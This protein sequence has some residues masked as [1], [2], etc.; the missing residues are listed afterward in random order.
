MLD[1]AYTPLWLHNL[2]LCN[3]N[4]FLDL[5][6]LHYV[7]PNVVNLRGEIHILEN[8]VDVSQF[9]RYLDLE[10]VLAWFLQ[11]GC[12][13][14]NGKVNGTLIELKLGGEVA[15]TPEILAWKVIS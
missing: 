12:F 8:A 1:A 11:C 9:L 5:L 6:L 13:I 3:L 2:W 14:V 10:A 4:Y 15:L 7:L